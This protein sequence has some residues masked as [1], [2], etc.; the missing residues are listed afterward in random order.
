MEGLT[1]R[2]GSVLAV[3]HLDLSVHPGE[4]FGFLGPNGAGKTTTIWMASGLLRPTSGAIRIFGMDPYRNPVEVKRLIG[5]APDEPPL[6]DRLTGRETLEFVGRVHELPS[7]EAAGRAEDLLGWLELDGAAS[8]RVGEYSMGMK[9]KLSLACVLIHKPRLMFLD[10][11]FSG[12]DP[13]GVKRIKDHLASLAHD[14]TTVFF[15][16]HVM[17]L[18]ERFCTRMAVIHE[19][20]LRA[21]GNVEEIRAGAGLGGGATLEEAFV[22]LVDAEP[23]GE[24]ASWMVP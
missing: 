3:D 22:K 10:E 17:E 9:K 18:V 1:R 2:Y 16:S 8:S 19:G 12:I 7:R 5:V 15:S 11:P 24:V 21:L 13:V 23:R 4:L 20:R 14:G 6:Y